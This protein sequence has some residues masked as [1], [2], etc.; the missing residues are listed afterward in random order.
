M[1]NCYKKEM[2]SVCVVANIPIWEKIVYKGEYSITNKFV[3][4]LKKIIP[5]IVKNKKEIRFFAENYI[6]YTCKAVEEVIPDVPGRHSAVHGFALNFSKKADL[7]SVFFT[8]FLV[9]YC[10]N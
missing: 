9:S 3:K 5:S 1:I 6:Y 2:Y 10:I 4:K 7:S 8:D